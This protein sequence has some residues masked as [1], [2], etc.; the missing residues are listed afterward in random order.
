MHSRIAVL[1]M[2]FAFATYS[3]DTAR[4]QD[5]TLL[6]FHCQTDS[7][8][9]TSDAEKACD[10]VYDFL[11]IHG[12]DPGY[13]ATKQV[14]IGNDKYYGHAACDG[15][16]SQDQCSKCIGIAYELAI[17]QCTFSNGAQVKFGSCRFRVDNYD[18]DHNW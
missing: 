17:K 3:W 9:P 8:E 2:A 15:N 12:E 6:A 4:G 7:H 16:I 18:F 13:S 11:R 5:M 1:I 10:E 14:K